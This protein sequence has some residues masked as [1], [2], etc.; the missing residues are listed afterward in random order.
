LNL[1]HLN[2]RIDAGADS[3]VR[4]QQEKSAHRDGMPGADGDNGIGER[5]QALRDGGSRPQHLEQLLRIA[6]EDR[7]VEARREHAGSAANHDHRLVGRRLVQCAAS[8][9]RSIDT[10]MTIRLAV[11]DRDRC[12]PS[13]RA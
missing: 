4:A 9:A 3:K 5:K 13:S 11:V 6:L 10:L 8:R 7:E 2:L 1:V 12:D